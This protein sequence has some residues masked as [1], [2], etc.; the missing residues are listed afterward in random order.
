MSNR[1]FAEQMEKSNLWQVVQQ[2]TTSNERFI[3][4]DKMQ[5]QDARELAS[6]MQRANDEAQKSQSSC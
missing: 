4:K 3:V 6:S 1:I 5:E 2:N